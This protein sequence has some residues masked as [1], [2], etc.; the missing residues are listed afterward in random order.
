MS[1]ESGPVEGITH[2]RRWRAVEAEDRLTIE[3]PCGT[4]V[5]VAS[6]DTM[7]IHIIIAALT[8]WRDE[9]PL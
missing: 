1:A 8:A 5:A 2:G 3:C 6:V 9:K 7:D 4:T